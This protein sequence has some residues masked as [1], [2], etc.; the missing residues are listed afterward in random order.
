MD[1]SRR[2]FIRLGAAGAAAAG[3]A[4]LAG[5]APTVAARAD[6][7]NASADGDWLGSA[8]ALSI[9]DCAETV[10]TDVLVVGSAL[11]GSMAAYG[12]L[13]NGAK[14]TVLERNAAP[15]IGGM[16]I[17]FLNSQT[18]LDAGLPEYDPV[19]TANDMFNLT[20][21]RSDMKLNTLWCERS[22]ELLDNL[23]A[24]FLEPYGQYCQPLSLEG[25]FPDPS[26]EITSYIST[27]VAFSETDILTDFTHNIHRYL[28]DEGVETRYSTC[29]E[30]LVQDEN[31]AVL[32]AIATNEDGEH[33]YFR[34]SK[35]VVMCTGSFGGDEAMMK[36]F[37]TTHFAE[38]ALK[39][40]AYEAYMGDD[41][42]T[43]NSMDDG[44]GHK[45]L[46]WAGAE[47]EEI[48]GYAA[49]QT[50]AWRSFPYLL[51]S[52]KGE[53]FMNECTSLLTSAHIV[54]DLPGHDGYV[55][56]I[57]P[58][59]DF[60]MPSS[61]GYDKEA[62]AKMFDI[63]KTEHYE[64]DTIEELAELIDVDPAALKA[65]VERYNEL[66]EKGEDV[67]YRKA[68]RYL[69]P[70]DDGPYQAWK[71]QYLFYCTLAGVRCNEKLQVLDADW[72]PIPGLY[73]GGNT[74]GYRFGAS[75]ESLLHG[76]SNGL[77]A[78]HAYVAG[79]SAAT[80]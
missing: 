73:A 3:L 23:K 76:G 37:Y 4:G 32:G 11:A 48:C 33:V 75:Y 43:D 39:N 70:I 80:R 51:V 35:G 9:D 77:A 38:W 15:H 60:E 78:T 25:I 53:R 52:T 56:Q 45:M 69:D 66:C 2:N 71:M 47:M 36:R 50:T 28:E 34:A 12:A 59:N 31:G 57:I 49:W 54:A 24:D 65:T 22:G 58:T 26:Q 16:T 8:P 27:G 68:K 62:A 40:N 21:Y 5:C 6:T 18:Q 72:N 64:A 55:W 42:V 46:C 63:E 29:A 10:E 20:Q 61:F 79:E 30:V 41:P 7:A 74:V 19:K 14:V 67:D 44:R 1:I 13:K 17:S